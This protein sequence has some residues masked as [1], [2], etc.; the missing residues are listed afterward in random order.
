MNT[1]QFQEF[2]FS[3]VPERTIASVMDFQEPS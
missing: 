3:D 1:S 2:F